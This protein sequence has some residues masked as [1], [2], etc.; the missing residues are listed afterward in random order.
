MQ[1]IGQIQPAVCFY[2]RSCI[3]TPLP[4]FVYI[5]SVDAFGTTMRADLVD[6][7]EIT[8]PAMPEIFII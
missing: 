6:A 1:P 3:G 7:T 2:K 4:P 5:L 8:R